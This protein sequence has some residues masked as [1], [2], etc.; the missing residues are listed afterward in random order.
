MVQ[1]GRKLSKSQ[2]GILVV[3]LGHDMWRQD[4]LFDVLASGDIRICVAWKT[5]KNHRSSKGIDLD[6]PFGWILLTIDLKLNVKC[7]S[8]IWENCRKRGL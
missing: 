4:I 2:K 8:V 6:H 7:F 1:T 5:F 3:D